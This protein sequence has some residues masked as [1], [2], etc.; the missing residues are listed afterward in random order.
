M[1]WTAAQIV[2][3]GG[4]LGQHR[5]LERQ[6]DIFEEQNIQEPGGHSQRD[7][8]R[9][10]RNIA[11]RRFNACKARFTGSETASET[12]H[13]PAPLQELNT[14]WT[15]PDGTANAQALARDPDLQDSAI[16]LVYDTEAD[17][18]MICS[19]ATGDDALLLLLASSDDSDST[20]PS[21]TEE[22]K[23]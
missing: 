6:P 13:L 12:A 21:A 19:A 23:R 2:R 7:N 9:F 20:P 3:L 5:H 22:T 10:D 8:R 4:I 14:R 15:G 16:K 1:A 11:A 17:A 18:S